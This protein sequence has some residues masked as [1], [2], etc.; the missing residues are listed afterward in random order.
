M[1]EALSARDIALQSLLDRRG[2]VSAHLDR[3]CA[4]QPDPAERALARQLAYGVTK[5][6]ITLRTIMRTLL[7]TPKKKFTVTTQN[8]ILL[9]LYQILFCDR[10]PTFAAVNE[11][12]EQVSRGRHKHH[13]GLVN[14]V[15][16]SAD[17]MFG[18]VQEGKAPIDACVIPV[19][20]NRYVRAD[21][22]LFS[23]PKEDPASYL[24]QAYSL[25]E[26]LAQRWLKRFGGMKG[27]VQLADHANCTAPLIVRVNTLKTSVSEVLDSLHKQGISAKPHGNGVSIVIEHAAEFHLLDELAEGLLQP[28]D[29]TATAVGLAAAPKPGM[30]VLDFCAAPGTKTTHLAELMRNTGSILAL[31]IP[32]K[33]HRIEENCQRMG[34][35]IV[36]TM[37]TEKVASLNP[38]SFDLVLADVP[39]SNTGVLARRPEARWRFDAKGLSKHIRDQ[40][41]LAAAAAIMVKPG[42]RLVYS[43]CSLEK[44]EGRD[45]VT[46]VLHDYPQARLI[47]EKQTMPAGAGDPQQWHDGG[48]VAIL[49]M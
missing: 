23:D 40:Q 38:Q 18:E 16:R 45:I 35:S 41:F 1:S 15:L 36:E 47:R 22:P 9:G 8:A 17:R 48:Y 5:H 34:I 33:L 14:A 49:E 46:R 30:Q 37:A 12:V 27:A 6:K 29:A 19:G 13:R 7:K 3:L 32:E 21:Q 42:G 39:C 31:D 26:L 2:N 43:T 11:A 24:T 44:E 28:Q 10:I 4:A 20:H 25:P